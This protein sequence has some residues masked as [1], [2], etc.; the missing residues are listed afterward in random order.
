[1]VYPFPDL[2]D[3]KIG[4]RGVTC[5]FIGYTSNHKGGCYRM[6]N[7]KTKMVFETHDVVFFNRMFLQVQV[8]ENT[9]KLQ[10]K[11]DPDDTELES[12]QQDERGGYYDYGF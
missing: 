11:Q 10:K 1:M 9:K 8:H 2:K 12:V 6:W 4:D 5:M 3:K 7:P